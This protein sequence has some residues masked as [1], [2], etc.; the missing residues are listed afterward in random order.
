MNSGGWY[1]YRYPPLDARLSEGLR[2]HLMMA[3]CRCWSQR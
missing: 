2:R 3:R 1:R